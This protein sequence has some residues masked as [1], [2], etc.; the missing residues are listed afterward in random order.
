MPVTD[1][2]PSSGAAEAPGIAGP[3]DNVAAGLWALVSVAGASAMTL[4]VREASAGMDTRMIVL[5]RSL[6]ILGVALAALPFL[7]GRGRLRFSRPWL[8]LLRG[9]LLGGSIQLG[10]HTIAHVP[11]ATATALFFTAPIFA[12]LLS[13]PIN[14]ER[15]GP[16]RLGAAAAGFV[17]ALVILRP[18]D[19]APD[20]AMLAALGSSLLFAL[21]L[22]LSKGVAQADGAVSAFLSS[23]AITALISV[24]LALPVWAAPGSSWI[25]AAAGAV[26]VMGA[27]RGLADLEAYR[28]GEAGVVGVVFYLRL[29]ALGALGWLVWDESPD[30]ATFV[31]AAVIVAS[32]L[33]IAHR[34]RAARRAV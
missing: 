27:V 23:V 22:A 17:G 21:A 9:I 15:L 2:P 18:F 30:A 14:G 3:H 19:A 32:T 25:W 6:M 4:A 29:P 8:H 11:L 24:P 16:R 13:A 20:P 33:Y 10:F 28:L 5:V 31:G 12:T 26:A 7:G 34:E 1:A